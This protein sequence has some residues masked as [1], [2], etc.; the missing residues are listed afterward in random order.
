MFQLGKSYCSVLWFTYSIYFLYSTIEP[1]S[2][3][4]ILIIVFLAISS[5]F[6]FC[7][8]SFFFG[9]F[10]FSENSLNIL[11]DGA[12]KFLPDN[13]NIWFLLMLTSINFLF[14]FMFDFSGSYYAEWLFIIPSTFWKLYY[15]TRDAIYSLFYQSVH[16]LRCSS[17]TRWSVC[18]VSCWVLQTPP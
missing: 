8:S 10:F 16:L 14:S 9:E 15:E 3:F 12:L 13:S 18:Y 5:P 17:H 7:Y 1:L 6:I 4:F 11:C 2:E